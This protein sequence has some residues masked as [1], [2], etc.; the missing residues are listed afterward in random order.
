RALKLPFT[1]DDRLE[2]LFPTTAIQHR[3][4]KEQMSLLNEIA[5]REG[6]AIEIARSIK[7]LTRGRYSITYTDDYFCTVVPEIN[8]LRHVSR[9]LVVD[10]LNCIAKDAPEQAAQSCLALLRASQSVGD[11][12]LVLAQLVRWG[13]HELTCYGLESILAHSTL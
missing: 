5:T 10:V 7:D 9:L 2:K 6:K 4:N 12:P 8:S 11:E 1:E 3:F 13:G